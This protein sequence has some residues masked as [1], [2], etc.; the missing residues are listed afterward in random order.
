MSTYEFDRISNRTSLLPG[1]RNH[2]PLKG[3]RG[4]TS[5]KEM[6][7]IDG[8]PKRNSPGPHWER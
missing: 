8:L 5:T 3:M 6:H 1:P 4:H 2:W 7:G